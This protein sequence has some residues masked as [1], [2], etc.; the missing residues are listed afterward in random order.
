[1]KDASFPIDKPVILGRTNEDRKKIHKCRNLKKKHLKTHKR[2]HEGET[3]LECPKCDQ[4][5]KFY[6]IIPEIITSVHLFKHTIEPK[7]NNQ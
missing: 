1:M 2:V 5:F 7:C 3:P 4:K 6:A